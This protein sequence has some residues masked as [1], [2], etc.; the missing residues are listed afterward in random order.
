L[1]SPDEMKL[2]QNHTLPIHNFFNKIFLIEIGQLSVENQTSADQFII[3]LESFLNLR[4][5]S[6]PKLK[7]H[8]PRHHID[9]NLDVEKIKQNMVDICEP[10]YDD[11]RKVLLNIGI[12]ASK[13]IR[14]YFLNADSVYVSQ[15]EKFEDLILQWEVDPCENE[16]DIESEDVV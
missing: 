7:Q 11:L 16:D 2:L 12:D 5:N 1:I 6:L 10:S 15:R 13:W 8:Q 9:L 14:E 4:N 3:D